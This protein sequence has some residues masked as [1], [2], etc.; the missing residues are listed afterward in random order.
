MD[1][2]QFYRRASLKV[3]LFRALVRRP[4]IF[5]FQSVGLLTLLVIFGFW[6]ASIH[7]TALFA[8]WAFVLLIAAEKMKGRL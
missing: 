2:V 6:M 5:A 7:W 1:A 3:S 8:F 4:T